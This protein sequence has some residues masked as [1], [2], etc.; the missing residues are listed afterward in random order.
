MGNDL[1]LK[2]L[3]DMTD[4]FSGADVSAVANTAISLV[5]H[6]YLERFP[7]PEEATKHASEALVSM[8]HFEEACE[9]DKEAERNETG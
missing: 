2:R 7:T 9:K 5:L 3:A 1:D 4:G 6:E 8:H